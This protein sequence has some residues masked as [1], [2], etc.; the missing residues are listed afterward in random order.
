M[1]WKHWKQLVAVVALVAMAGMVVAE[2][3]AAKEAKDS[4]PLALVPRLGSAK[5][6]SFVGVDSAGRLIGVSLIDGTHAVALDQAVEEVG[7]GRA[8]V[9]RLYLAGSALAFEADRTQIHQILAT[10][11]H[12]GVSGVP[13]HPGF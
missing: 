3:S 7:S 1:A 11:T 9:W 10:K 6:P 12:D 4:G 13:L 5:P 8:Q 2:G